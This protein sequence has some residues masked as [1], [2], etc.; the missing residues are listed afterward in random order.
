MQSS[1]RWNVQLGDEHWGRFTYARPPGDPIRLLGSITR[2][3][4][5]GA[6]AEEA[7]GRYVQVN[8]DHVTPLSDSQ[9]RHAVAAARLAAPRPRSRRMET[10]HTVVV[11]V[12]RR[13][14]FTHG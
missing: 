6:L 4:Q 8:G 14:I 1:K 3:A 10:L 11:T 12:K 2:G 13:R 5:I 9:V 7:D